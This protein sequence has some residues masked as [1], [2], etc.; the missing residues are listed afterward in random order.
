MESD[1]QLLERITAVL[2]LGE[3][4]VLRQRGITIIRWGVVVARSPEAV[5]RWLS[6]RLEKQK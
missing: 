3:S 4:V 2:Q 1:I 6:R 5:D